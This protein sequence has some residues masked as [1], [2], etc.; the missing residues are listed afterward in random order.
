MTYNDQKPY[1]ECL[2]LFLSQNRLFFSFC[3]FPDST[4][5]RNYYRLEIIQ[6]RTYSISEAANDSKM[7]KNDKKLNFGKMVKK[8]VFFMF[9]SHPFDFRSRQWLKN[10]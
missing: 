9:R 3:P 5:T 8:N 1:F 6:I 2:S 4:E 10:A 7:L